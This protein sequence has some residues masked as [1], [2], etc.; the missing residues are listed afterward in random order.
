MRV[1]YFAVEGRTD[2][3]VAERLIESVGCRPQQA[4]VAGSKSRL[5]PRLPALNRSGT[6]LNW[7][8]LRDLDRDAPCASRLV[9]RLVGAGTR[10]PRIAVRVPIRAI[11]SWLLA[12]HEWYD[13]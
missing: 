9:R 2:V 8:I 4:I 1:V 13:A 10:H 5:D 6:H 12:D 3:P 7:L 11:E